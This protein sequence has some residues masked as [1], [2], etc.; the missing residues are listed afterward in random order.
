MMVYGSSWAFWPMTLMAIG[1]LIF[2]AL[3]VWVAYAVFAA[4]A[5]QA[6]DQPDQAAQQ[7]LDERLA[8][9]E[10]DADEYQRLT[11]ELDAAHRGRKGR[12]AW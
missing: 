9:G 11:R 5:R 6:G 12:G 7:I 3:V 4:P 10:L 8:R 2:C 1:S